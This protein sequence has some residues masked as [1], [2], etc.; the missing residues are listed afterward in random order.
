MVVE[1]SEGIDL[2]DKFREMEMG[3]KGKG[4]YTEGS[5]Q[6][7]PVTAAGLTVASPR[8]RRP[9]RAAVVTVKKATR[10]KTECILGMEETFEPER[11]RI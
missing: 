9:G 3:R 10:A 6:V 11:S 8:M 5:V 2:L 1:S 7:V 4:R